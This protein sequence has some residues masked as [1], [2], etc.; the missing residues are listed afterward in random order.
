MKPTREQLLEENL[1]WASLIARNVKRKL[2]ASFDLCDLEQVAHIELWRRTQ[3]WDPEKNDSFRGYAY[4]PVRGAVLMSVRR[5]HFREATHESLDEVMSERQHEM[6]VDGL[7]ISD[8][9]ITQRE[10]EY[11]KRRAQMAT[12][13]QLMKTLPVEQ[14]YLIRRID[15]NEVSPEAVALCWGV[16]LARIAKQLRSA[17]FTLKLALKNSAPATPTPA[18]RKDGWLFLGSGK[19]GAV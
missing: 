13:I 3:L 6:A 11:L 19:A 4:L 18:R 9:V 17:R 10:A 16:S 14:A 15:L 12:L 2:P 1:S 5:R 7:S 8:D